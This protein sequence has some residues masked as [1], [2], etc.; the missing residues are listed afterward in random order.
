MDWFGNGPDDGNLRQIQS[1][2]IGQ[3]ST[4]GTPVEVSTVIGVYL[5][6]GSTGHVYRVFNINV[7]FSTAVLDTT[8][9]QQLSGAAAIRMAAGHSIAFEP[10]GE[11]Q[12]VL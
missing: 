11:L 10:P 5:A 3:H 4:S 2:V 1:L 8:N 9:A 6:G 12:P 7:P